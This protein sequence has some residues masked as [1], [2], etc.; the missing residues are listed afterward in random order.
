[1]HNSVWSLNRLAFASYTSLLPILVLGPYSLNV[2]DARHAAVQAHPT[3]PKLPPLP[4]G[5]HELK[6]SD[7]FKSPV[8]PLGLELTDKVKQLDGRR[9]RILGFMVRQTDP[10]TNAF[11]LT[12]VPVQLHEH[13]YGLADDLPASAL[14]V[15]LPEKDRALVPFTPGLL[16]VTGTL[17]LGARDIEGHRRTWVTLDMD[18]AA[19]IT[20][21]NQRKENH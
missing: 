9:V 2:E 16:L 15:R 14:Y 17:R 7:F 1:M 6:F 4:P 8:G 20:I 13:E 5:V 3:P 18:P 19:R 11:L 12:S 10:W 21:Q